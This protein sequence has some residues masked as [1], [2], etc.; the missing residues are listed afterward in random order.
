MDANG[1]IIHHVDD[2]QGEGIK[3]PLTIDDILAADPNYFKDQPNLL[4]KM[5]AFQRRKDIRKNP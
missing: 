5:M 4:D 2:D 3:D 1:N